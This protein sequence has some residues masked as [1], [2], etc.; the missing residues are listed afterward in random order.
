MVSP[1]ARRLT[2]WLWM[3]WAGC[4]DADAPND[5]TDT[6]PF[7]FEV[8]KGA[9][10]GSLAPALVEQ[11][12]VGAEW[13]WKMFLRTEDMSCLKAGRFKVSRSMSLHELKAALCGPPLSEDEPF[14]VVEGWRIRDIDA[15]LVEKG[16]IKPGDYA[17]VALNKSVELPFPIESKTLEG[18]LYPE[19][20][21]VEPAKF[22]VEKLI[23]RQLETFRSRFLVNHE[24]DVQ[25]RGL[26]AIVIMAS[27]LER[28]EPKPEQRPVTAGILWKRLD[29]GWQLGV[30]A[31]SRYEL[32][33]WNDKLAFLKKLRDPNDPYNSR[34]NKGLPPTAI[35]NPSVSSLEA[36]LSPVAS[37][38]W[39]YLHDA[40]HNFHGGRNVEEH[41]ANRKKYNVY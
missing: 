2:M 8:K 24:K 5:P 3:V 14:T 4:V 20:Y 6:T 37:E 29:A 33:E 31:T 25:K 9:V 21:R 41:E 32:P 13:K 18:Y 39:Y 16:W 7:V 22:S 27:M 34:L 19:T 10:P 38:Y 1:G 26:D 40:E 23:G 12:L 35:G 28:E 11:R 15:A 30:D 17:T 36:A